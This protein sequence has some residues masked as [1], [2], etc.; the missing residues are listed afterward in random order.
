[1]ENNSNSWMLMALAFVAVLVVVILA[2]LIA[3]A[4]RSDFNRPVDIEDIEGALADSDVEMCAKGEFTWNSTPGFVYGRFYDFSSNCS[5]SDPNKPGA[6]VWVVEFDSAESRDAALRNFET[7]RRHTGS[8]MAWSNGPYVI[9][10]DGNKRQEEISILKEAIS[11]TG[12][13]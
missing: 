5:T 2:A 3:G 13:S 9:L 4:P 7:Q 12:A 8:G 10:I 6:R 1:M 11:N